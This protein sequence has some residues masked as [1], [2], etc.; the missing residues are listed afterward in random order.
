M[1]SRSPAGCA[2]GLPAL[3][4]TSM[5]CAWP[6]TPRRNT[7]S[8]MPRA[9]TTEPSWIRP[10]RGRVIFERKAISESSPCWSHSNGALRP[11]ARRGS[12]PTSLAP[13]SVPPVPKS[14]PHFLRKGWP[15][16]RNCAS[17][18]RGAGCAAPTRSRGW[19]RAY[20]VAPFPPGPGHAARPGAVD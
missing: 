12:A 16:T 20:W 18:S 10:V 19:M 1:A 8:A 13:R 7:P 15:G 3:Q 17:I 11:A 6:L 4:S 9:T 14:R 5:F 2:N